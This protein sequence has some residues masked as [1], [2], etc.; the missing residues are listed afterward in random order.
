MQGDCFL[1]QTAM[2]PV[3]TPWEL[4]ER[5]DTGSTPQTTHDSIVISIKIKIHQFYPK[6]DRTLFVKLSTEKRWQTACNGPINPKKRL[7]KWHLPNQ[8]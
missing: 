1:L 2:V 6:Y 4:C 7:K 5:G 8:H 3:F